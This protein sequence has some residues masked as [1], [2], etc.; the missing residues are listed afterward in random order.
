MGALLFD[1]HNVWTDY[2]TQIDFPD[3]VHPLY[4]TYAGNGRA[5]LVQFELT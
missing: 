3:G 5:S 2:T 4:I 1:S